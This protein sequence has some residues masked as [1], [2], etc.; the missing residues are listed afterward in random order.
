LGIGA[1]KMLSQLLIKM[2]AIFASKETS[3]RA[4]RVLKISWLEHVADIFRDRS[5]EKLSQDSDAKE[6]TSTT[7]R[8]SSKEP[9]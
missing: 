1:F 5:S 6:I 4:F 9:P 8:R 7:L 3:E 2:I